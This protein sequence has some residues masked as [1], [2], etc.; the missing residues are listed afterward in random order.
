MSLDRG[1]NVRKFIYQLGET[2]EQIMIYPEL[3]IFPLIKSLEV[4]GFVEAADEF[5]WLI[6]KHEVHFHIASGAELS[7]VSLVQYKW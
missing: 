3:P 7:F 4:V 6:S 1:R 5:G 2:V